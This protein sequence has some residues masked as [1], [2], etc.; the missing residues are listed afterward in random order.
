MTGT[1]KSAARVALVAALVVLAAV[2]V[3]GSLP[4]GGRP[5]FTRDAISPTTAVVLLIAILGVSLV[6]LAVATVE[7]L[8]RPKSPGPVA[9]ERMDW[10]RREGVRPGRRF[11]FVAGALSVV[12]VLLVLFLARLHLGGPAGELPADN[13]RG[14]AQTHPSV[15]PQPP[16][17]PVR[18]D[19]PATARFLLMASAAFLAI[20]LLLAAVGTIGARR[21]RSSGAVSIPGTE[22]G[23]Q[24]A[25][26]AG[27]SL[28]RAATL[29]L[30]EVDD[31]R[32]QPRAAIIACYAVMEQELARVPRAAPREFDTATE[33]LAR[34]IHGAALRS[35]SA[36]PL[37]EL[38]TE[39]RFSPHVMDEGH[40][41]VA[42]RSL[43]LVLAELRGVP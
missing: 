32:R 37:V 22:D 27:A 3:R 42:L 18:P 40:R 43:R 31:P 16:P 29:G 12:S 8:R 21:G 41:E 39:A 33:V 24:P 38:F 13:A 20:F 11:W 14:P 26:A 7:R 17:H 4:P 2:A 30:A 35:D 5:R 1:D 28:A 15:Y 23:E 10:T 19:D 9:V 36:A 25:D 6:I 34:A